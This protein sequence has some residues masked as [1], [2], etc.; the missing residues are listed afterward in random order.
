MH[1]RHHFMSFPTHSKQEAIEQMYRGLS[2]DITI[3]SALGRTS[4]I[5]EPH[6]APG[7][8]LLSTDELVKAFQDKFPHFSIRAE[9]RGILVDWS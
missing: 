5:Y 8:T 2:R 4:Y 9:K 1:R 6:F 7:S 3:A